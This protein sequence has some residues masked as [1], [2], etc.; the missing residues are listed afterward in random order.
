MIYSKTQSNIPEDE[1]DYFNNFTEAANFENGLP[2]FYMREIINEEAEVDE[3]YLLASG[4]YSKKL[5]QL[6]S[7][8]DMEKNF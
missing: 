3:F 7:S 6:F 8:I 4:K 2:E 1:Q 5:R